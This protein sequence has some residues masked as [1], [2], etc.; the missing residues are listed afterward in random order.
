MHEIIP[1]NRNSMKFEYNIHSQRLFPWA[2]LNAP[3]EGAWCSIDPHTSSLP[4]SHHEHEIFIA[5]KGCATILADGIETPFQ[6]GDIVHFTPGT[7]HTVINNGTEIFEMYSI[8][9][10]VEMAK[11]FEINNQISDA[12]V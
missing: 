10:D 7:N 1:L 3:F 4:H 11:K 12:T 9:W 5:I 2:L 8:W 6:S